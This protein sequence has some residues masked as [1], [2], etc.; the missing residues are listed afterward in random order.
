MEMQE[1]FLQIDPLKIF[2][3]RIGNQCRENWEEKSFHAKIIN[4]QEGVGKPSTA[5]HVL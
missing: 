4:Y 5:K 3:E 2:W 1:S